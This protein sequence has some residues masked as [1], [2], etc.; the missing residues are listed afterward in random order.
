MVNNVVFEDD[1]IREL[2]K[3]KCY[4]DSLGKGDLFFKDIENH[5]ELIKEMPFAFQIRYKSVRIIALE[6]F[7]Y[8]I[9]YTIYKKTIVVLNILNQ[10]QD[11]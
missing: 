11:F 1:A 5:I 3:A 2:N 6:K 8:T 7:S 9:H 10:S 4:F